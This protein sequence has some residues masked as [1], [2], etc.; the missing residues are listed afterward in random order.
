M[1]K[2]EVIH[3]PTVATH[4]AEVE[5]LYEM[6]DRLQD[7]LE[8]LQDDEETWAINYCHLA[9]AKDLIFSV[10]NRLERGDDD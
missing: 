9:T 10:A 8:C 5:E 6:V 4:Q 1:S 2:G 7:I 3:L